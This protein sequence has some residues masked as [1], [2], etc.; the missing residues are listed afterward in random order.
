M[1]MN[2]DVGVILP[3][4]MRMWRFEE[5]RDDVGVLVDVGANVVAEWVSTRW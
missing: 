4:S 1:Q 5:C 3:V 2:D